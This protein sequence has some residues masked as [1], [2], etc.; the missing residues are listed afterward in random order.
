VNS[1]GGISIPNQ[2]FG[3]GTISGSITSTGAVNYVISI[4]GASETCSF[5]LSL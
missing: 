4:S 2:A 5:N 1:D 3:N